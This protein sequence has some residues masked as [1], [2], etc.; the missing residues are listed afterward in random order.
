MADFASTQAQSKGVAPSANYEGGQGKAAVVA[1][2]N[3]SPPPTADGV[4]KL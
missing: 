1:A 2:L 4:D 3:A